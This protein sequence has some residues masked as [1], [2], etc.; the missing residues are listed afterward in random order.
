MSVNSNSQLPDFFLV[1]VDEGEDLCF[2]WNAWFD[3][4]AV[5]KVV[6]GEGKSETR[7]HSESFQAYHV[8]RTMRNL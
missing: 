5:P 1:L 4:E 3:D 8:G 2:G 6:G 7:G